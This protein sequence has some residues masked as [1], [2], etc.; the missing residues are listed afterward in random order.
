MEVDLE[1]IPQHQP[2]QYDE[3]LIRECVQRLHASDVFVY[4]NATGG[5]IGLP[6]ELWGEYKSSGTLLGARTPYDMLE[7]QDIL[8][9]K[10]TSYCSLDT[11]CWLATAA[12]RR[13]RELRIRAGDL[14]PNVIGLGITAALDRGE[15]MRGGHRAFLVSRSNDGLRKVE[16]RF[17]QY[18]R[19]CDDGGCGVFTRRDEGRLCDLVGLGMLMEAVRL[20]DEPLIGLLPGEPRNI[21]SA[22]LALLGDGETVQAQAV[23]S[24]RLDPVVSDLNAMFARPVFWPDGRCGTVDD[25]DPEQHV[26]Y[27]GSFDPLHQGHE[28][29]ARQL[30]RMF[31][32]KKVVFVMNRF[33]PVKGD[34]TGELAKRLEQFRYYA[35]ALV[36]ES[37]LFIEK[38]EQLPPGFGFLI[39]TDVLKG[40]L[41]PKY[42]VGIR[43]GL[44]AV[45]AKFDE[46]GTRFF[47]T[48]RLDETS[49]DFETMNDV[50]IP[51]R[52]AH[53]FREVTGRCDAASH[54]LREA[55]AAKA[56]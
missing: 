17:S 30:E 21:F 45:L 49:G 8:G 23:R 9:F 52:Y 38:A 3:K 31:P 25:L 24:K 36:M 48:G 1:D 7:T 47:V 6:A 27:C 37:G 19:S 40:L 13:A 15:Y 46:R 28:M 53:L 56:K 51:P 16:L 26:L 2:V 42:Y 39:G 20:P 18:D 10:P 33:H 55:A 29:S 32:G 35:P 11:A 43:G 22:E 4:I 41:D 5:G 54:L 34:V 14:T 44:N 12:Y 50:P